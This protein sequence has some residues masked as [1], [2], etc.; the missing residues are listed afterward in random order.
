MATIIVLDAYDNRIKIVTS[1]DAEEVKKSLLKYGWV[2]N[3]VTG[4][5]YPLH[6]VLEVR[7]EDENAD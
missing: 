6:R 5:S 7:G 4:S 2:K 3:W 1:V